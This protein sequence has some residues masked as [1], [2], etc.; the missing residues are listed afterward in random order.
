MVYFEFQLLS[1]WLYGKLIANPFRKLKIHGNN[2]RQ[3]GFITHSFWIKLNDS[4]N[5]MPRPT[6]LQRSFTLSHNIRCGISSLPIIMKF[7]VMSLLTYIVSKIIVR[8]QIIVFFC[9]QSIY[10]KW[11]PQITT[12]TTL[13]VLAYNFE[14][15]TLINSIKLETKSEFI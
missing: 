6:N 5:R 3:Q 7:Y 12:T 2:L 11:K 13:I 8:S 10:K 1:S 4:K 9:H 15:K 14:S